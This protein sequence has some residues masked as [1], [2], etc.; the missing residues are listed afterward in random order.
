MYIVHQGEIFHFTVLSLL[1]PWGRAASMD[2][3]SLNQEWPFI[4]IVSL[5]FALNLVMQAIPIRIHKLVGVREL[6]NK[7]LS[8]FDRLLGLGNLSQFK[9]V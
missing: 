2:I 5:S 8:H 3:I 7:R 1:W 9:V 4:D 6:D